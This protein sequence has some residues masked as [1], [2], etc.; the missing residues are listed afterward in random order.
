MH[1]GLQEDRQEDL[2]AGFQHTQLEL[3]DRTLVRALLTRAAQSPD[4]RL[5]S[6]ID[7]PV[8]TAGEVLAEVR[9][10]GGALH[11]LGAR[12][13]DRVVIVCGNRP[14][15]VTAFFG[16]VFA[17]CVPV[18]VN[19]A[20]K[21]DTLAAL[22]ADV[23]PS[24]VIVEAGLLKTIDVG[25]A[26]AGHAATVVRIGGDGGDG[27]ELDF[28]ELVAAAQ[29]CEIPDPEPSEL[30]L[31]L[32]TS[33][34]TGP[35]KGVMI[36]HAMTFGWV[37][38]RQWSMRL[39]PEDVSFS[40]LPLFHVGTLFNT[41]LPIMVAGGEAAIAERFSASRYWD[42]VR[43]TRATILFIIGSMIPI[44]WSRPPSSQDRD[45]AARIGL[46]IPCPT[47]NFH[48]FQE[49]FGFPMTAAFGMTDIGTVMGVPYGVSQ[50]PGSAGRPMPTWECDIVDEN[51]V[52]VAAGEVGELVARPRQPWTMQLGYWNRL[53]ATVQAWRNLWFHTGD[54]FRRD[55][56]GWYYFVDRAKDAIRR[57]GENISSYE[58]E[59]ALLAH[60]AVAEAAVFPV[61]SEL[62]EDE[63]MAVITWR[64]GRSATYQELLE[65]CGERLPYF[66]V[67]RFVEALDQLPKTET[68]KIKKAEL[69]ARGVAGTT[70]DRGARA[71]RRSDVVGRKQ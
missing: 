40:C 28:D 18:P 29:P 32:Y 61:P 71:E 44:L 4:S 9:R 22:L 3:R 65:H 17:G 35:A 59:S 36:P 8:L 38:N 19:T 56:D 12:P 53:D 45:H 54:R 1:D 63:V 41:V 55:A 26:A 58:V 47:E 15:F 13:G 48:E 7:G 23:T 33:G 6:F 43:A 16:A 67:P 37:D 5:L 24:V 10:A 70:F 68:E 31:I 2:D 62:A 60:A 69:R 42:Q 66:A 34:T 30:A 20:A 14:Q 52:P 64:V 51:D 25:L 49:R 46:V 27:G 57:F 50:P 11:G 39:G 21:G